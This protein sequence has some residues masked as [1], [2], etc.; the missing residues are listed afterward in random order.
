VFFFFVVVVIVGFE[1][2]L[3]LARQAF[4]YLSHT[5]SP[6]CFVFQIG[7]LDFVWGWPQT[8]ILQLL[9]PLWLGLEA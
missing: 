1:L 7:S 9:P 2:G 8:R 6:F 5:P 3:A 4:Y